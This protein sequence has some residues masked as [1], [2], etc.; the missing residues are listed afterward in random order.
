MRARID[1]ERLSAEIEELAR[2]SDSPYPSVTRILFTDADMRAR[3]WLT[4]RMQEAGLTVRVD[5]VGNIFGRWEGADP[6]A[7]AVATVDA[8]CRSVRSKSPALLI[9]CTR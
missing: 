3:R 8:T 1:V 2:I 5:A 6:A 4:A 7:A 9:E